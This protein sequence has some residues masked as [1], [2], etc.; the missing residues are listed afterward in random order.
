MI[1]ERDG[2]TQQGDGNEMRE[3]M[4]EG[5]WREEFGKKRGCV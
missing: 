2:D 4:E 1:K 3:R 5:R